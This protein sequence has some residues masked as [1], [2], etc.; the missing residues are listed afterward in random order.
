MRVIDVVFQSRRLGI[1]FPNE[2][3]KN[4][5]LIVEVLSISGLIKI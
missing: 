1:S 4:R 5:F 3:Y 2:I